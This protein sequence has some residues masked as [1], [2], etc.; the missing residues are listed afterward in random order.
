M[1]TVE[2]IVKLSTDRST[3]CDECDYCVGRMGSDIATDADHYITEHGYKILHVGQ[4][5]G[6]DNEGRPFQ[7][8]V[9][10]LG[11]EDRSN[12]DRVKADREAGSSEL[13]HFVASAPHGD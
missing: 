4:E 13:D 7:M 10:V 5:K 3:A 1:A 2:H 9:I 11:V 12:F 8:T 6:L